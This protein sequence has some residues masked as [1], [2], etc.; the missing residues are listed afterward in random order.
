MRTS[1]FPYFSRVSGGMTGSIL[2]PL[3]RL[4][5]SRCQTEG[6]AP[7]APG[8]ASSRPYRAKKQEKQKLALNVC[9]TPRPFS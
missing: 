1:E 8:Y 4:C 9:I 7:L 2:S 3:A 6:C 5:V